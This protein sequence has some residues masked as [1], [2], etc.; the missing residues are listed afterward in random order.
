ML[1]DKVK[2]LYGATDIKSSIDYY[3]MICFRGGVAMSSNGTTTIICPTPE[4]KGDFCVS[5]EKLFRLC[6]GFKTDPDIVVEDRV[7]LRWDGKF[8]F[9]IAKY[10]VDIFPDLRR[11]T[12]DTVYYEHPDLADAISQVLFCAE[13]ETDK[14]PI[15]G[16]YLQDDF[17]MACNGKEMIKHY[18]TGKVLTECRLDYAAAVLI[19][20]QKQACEG[21]CRIGNTLVFK[22]TDFYLMSRGQEGKFPVDVL[23]PLFNQG[24]PECQL[25]E[26]FYA[27]LNVLK[28]FSLDKEFYVTFEYDRDGNTTLKLNTELNATI[29]Y[30]GF[31]PR[32]PGKFCVRGDTLL[33]A[34]KHLG[35]KP[36]FSVVQDSQGLYLSGLDSEFV[37]ILGLVS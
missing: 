32:S 37:Y 7:Y 17:V 24:F 9:S 19:S 29:K 23:N 27:D 15:N 33:T 1:I 36:N 16:V 11:F 22:F 13:R 25:P 4:V 12:T 5:A 3:G 10:D 35:K 26:T 8:N 34:L 28:Q 6:K 18:L 14:A 2:I 30:P 20:K 31:L 21:V